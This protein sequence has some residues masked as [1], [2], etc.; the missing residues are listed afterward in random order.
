MAPTAA[1]G[2]G[3][4]AGGRATALL[5]APRS[6]RRGRSGWWP[7]RR[8]QLRYRRSTRVPTISRRSSARRRCRRWW[9]PRVRRGRRRSRPDITAAGAGAGGAATGR[10]PTRRGRRRRP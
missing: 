7:L 4:A 1:A 10:V 8:R 5:P 2:A 9:R 6:G 3:G